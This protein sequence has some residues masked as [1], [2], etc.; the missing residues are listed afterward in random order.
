MSTPVLES[1]MAL[2]IIVCEI[3]LRRLHS[4]SGDWNLGDALCFQNMHPYIRL[5]ILAWFF[6]MV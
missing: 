1:V 4:N 5:L 3:Y 2:D 6:K